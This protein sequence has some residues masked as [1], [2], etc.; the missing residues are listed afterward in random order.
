VVETVGVGQV[1]VEIAGH[2]DTTVVVVNPAWGDSV[3]AAKAG[4][5][6]IADIFVI[7]KADRSGADGTEADL[8]GM[9]ELA[10]HKDWTPPIVKTIATTGVGVDVLYDEIASHRAHV[11]ANGEAAARRHERL[12]EELR[13]LV[14]AKMLERADA[15]CS[16]AT[17]DKLV[18]EI[19]ARTQ[20]PYTAADALLRNDPL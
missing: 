16:D 8:R 3:Q 4:L 17:F 7:N 14:A 10:G 11:V 12:R 13:M 15:A 1:E 5:L 9:L 19:E 20:D 2:A 18:G 6:E